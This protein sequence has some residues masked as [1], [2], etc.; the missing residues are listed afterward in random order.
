M[1]ECIHAYV[2]IYTCLE[3]LRGVASCAAG[4]DVVH[5]KVRQRQSLPVC[6]CLYWWATKSV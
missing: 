1:C 3:R 6:V 4:L 2:F 5:A